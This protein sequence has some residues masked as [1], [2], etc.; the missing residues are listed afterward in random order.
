MLVSRLREAKRE[1]V[2]ATIGHEANAHETENHHGPG[3]GLGD[4]G[5]LS[6][7]KSIKT[8]PKSGGG[9]PEGSVLNCA[10]A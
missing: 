7:V 8:A 5:D 4:R 6:P 9:A 3:G 10:I 2:L 1:F